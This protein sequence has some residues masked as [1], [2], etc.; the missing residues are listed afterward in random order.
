MAHH[1]R[2]GW[3]AMSS[4][5]AEAEEKQQDW[6]AAA[7]S[8]NAQKMKLFTQSE[9]E[10]VPTDAIPQAVACKAA[11]KNQEETLKVLLDWGVPVS[12]KDKAPGGQT[13]LHVAAGAGAVDSVRLLIKRKVDVNATDGMMKTAM[14]MALKGN[15]LAVMK[16]LL[17]AGATVPLGQKELPAGAHNVIKE[18][19]LEK[20]MQEIKGFSTAEKG[21]SDKLVEAEKQVWKGMRAHMQ[22][23]ERQEEI[24]VAKVVQDFDE[25]MRVAQSD[26]LDA[27]KIEASLTEELKDLKV[28]VQAEQMKQNQVVLEIQTMQSEEGQKKDVEEELAKDVADKQA[29]L[30]QLLPVL[31]AEQGALAKAEAERDVY[32]AECDGMN[33][34]IEAGRLE[35]KELANELAESRKELAGL[36]K[37]RRRLAELQA[38]AA[39]LHGTA[40]DAAASNAG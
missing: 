25:R 21:L 11:V 6:T 39:D 18:V 23:L 29:E 2:A 5:K 32:V 9:G 12:A 28:L 36:R 26:S 20:Q 22:L 27:S 19:Q 30:N 34:V 10:W 1:P 14:H 15:H 13:L 33:E 37:D 40:D 4:R 24:R 38:E 35:N 17:L 16:E 8:G 31:Q 3:P 7:E